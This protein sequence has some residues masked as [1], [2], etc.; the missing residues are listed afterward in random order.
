VATSVAF[1]RKKNIVLELSL[2]GAKRITQ[3]KY[4]SPVLNMFS[5]ISISSTIQATAINFQIQ[6][7]FFKQAVQEYLQ[8]YAGE[9]EATF[10]IADYGCADAKNSVAIYKDVSRKSDLVNFLFEVIT[11]TYV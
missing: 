9:A 3:Q 4:T 6:R 1:R 10:T 2:T 5:F 11:N 8:N 7:G